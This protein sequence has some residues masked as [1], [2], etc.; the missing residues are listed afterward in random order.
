MAPQLP[1]IDHIATTTSSAAMPSS[2]FPTGALTTMTSGISSSL[3]AFP[4][5]SLADF[6]ACYHVGKKDRARLE[7]LEF[8]P[9][10]NINDLEAEE[11]KDCAGFVPLSWSHI[12]TKNQQFLTMLRQESGVNS[13]KREVFFATC[14]V[15][16]PKFECI[17]LPIPKKLPSIINDITSMMDPIHGHI[18]GDTPNQLKQHQDWIFIIL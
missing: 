4:D 12:K 14:T 7:T 8:H 17:L 5:V 18:S 2:S 9:G 1:I 15:S 3:L 6:C 16:Y 13:K 11:W 10:D